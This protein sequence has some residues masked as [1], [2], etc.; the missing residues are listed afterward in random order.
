MPELAKAATDMVKGPRKPAFSL[1]ALVLALAELTD[2]RTRGEASARG[3]QDFSA[4]T[5]ATAT[6]SSTSLLRFVAE[7]KPTEE[8]RRRGRSTGSTC[9]PFFDDYSPPAPAL[10][11]TSGWVAFAEKAKRSAYD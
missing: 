4:A 2:G 11:S 8:W 9:P 10:C 1:R 7:G 3:R 5:R 6:S